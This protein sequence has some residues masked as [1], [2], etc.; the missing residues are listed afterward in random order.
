MSCYCA[1]GFSH[2]HCHRGRV[3]VD[4]H[5]KKHIL[6]PTYCTIWIKGSILFIF[7]RVPFTKIGDFDHHLRKS[8]LTS[9]PLSPRCAWGRVL[10]ICWLWAII[11]QNLFRTDSFAI[12]GE[13]I[14]WLPHR[15]VVHHVSYANFSQ[16]VAWFLILFFLLMAAKNVCRAHFCSLFG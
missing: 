3:S 7:S 6:F 12:G 11:E 4:S 15:N 1:D 14:V 9:N 10:S 2:S 16:I 8:S 5:P 13:L